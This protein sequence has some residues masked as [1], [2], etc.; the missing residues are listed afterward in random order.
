MNQMIKTSVI[1]SVCLTDPAAQLKR[2]CELIEQAANQGAKL[3][4]LP[5]LCLS[6]YFCQAADPAHFALAES[7]PGPSTDVFGEL[8]GRLGVV[9]VASLFERRA[10]GLYHNTTAVL[11]SDGS[12]AGI[13]RKMHIPDDPGYYEK[14]YFTPGDLGFHPIQTSIGRLGVLICWDQWFPEAARCMTLNGADLLIYPTAIGWDSRDDEAEKQRQVDSW[15]TIQRSHAI[16]N[17]IPVISC[18]RV[19]YEPD[20]S[21]Q[22]VGADF[23]G[24]SMII[25]QQGEWL[26]RG[27]SEETLLYADLDLSRTETVRQ[28]WPFLR[29]RR[30]DDFSQLARRFG[31]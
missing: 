26:A 30:I 10:P 5:E 25:G 21:N 2:M 20:P 18:N 14:Y 23:W 31:N 11:D 15:E 13:Y 19:G 28:I 9:I 3:I 16:A 4:V 24:H 29:D 17:G 1:Q 7:I 12:L 22:T 6:P 8:A 27:G